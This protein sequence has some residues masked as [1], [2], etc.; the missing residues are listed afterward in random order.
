LNPGKGLPGVIISFTI[1]TINR[2]FISITIMIAEMNN[3]IILPN[4]NP[5]K[6]LSERRD[7]YWQPMITT[8][9]LHAFFH[10]RGVQC[11]LR[12]VPHRAPIYLRASQVT[13]D[14]RLDH[15]EMVWGLATPS[16][17]VSTGGAVDRKGSVGAHG[18]VDSAP[19]TC[20]PTAGDVVVYGKRCHPDA[21][22]KA[23]DYITE[24]I[25]PSI[26]IPPLQ[27]GGRVAPGTGVW[28]DLI[29]HDRPAPILRRD[30]VMW[31]DR[32]QID[33]L[34]VSRLID[35]RDRLYAKRRYLVPLELESVGKPLNKKEQAARVTQ[36]IYD[37]LLRVSYN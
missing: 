36:H 16:G 27:M 6:S 17:V 2:L 12:L 23:A 35:A 15:S 37:T 10:N 20:G 22:V 32:R 9:A 30:G 29:R 4:Q 8:D 14:T 26:Y 21:L 28:M 1:L 34:I 25:A 24:A 31:V 33:F 18:A 5:A 3:N 11:Q 7:I 19:E 13:P